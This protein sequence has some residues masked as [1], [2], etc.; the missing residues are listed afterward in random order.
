M[1]AMLFKWCD[2]PYVATLEVKFSAMAMWCVFQW[3][4]LLCSMTEQEW[5]ELLELE[6][7]FILGVCHPAASVLDVS[8]PSF[9]WESSESESCAPSPFRAPV[10][11][12]GFNL[13]VSLAAI[14][15]PTPQ[16]SEAENFAVEMLRQQWATESS[17]LRLME[18]LSVTMR[19]FQADGDHA[20]EVN[21]G[22]FSTG[23][24]VYSSKSDLCCM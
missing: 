2:E 7:P 11:D 13:A 8:E 24:Y 4:E 23:A 5:L 1:N 18:L 12:I 6:A 9:C 14:P 21:S 22:A 17:L 19:P 10:E 3:L 15:E 16:F 20:S